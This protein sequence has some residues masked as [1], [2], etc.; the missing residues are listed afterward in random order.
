VEVF[1]GHGFILFTPWTR[2]EDVAENVRVI[3]D[4]APFLAGSIGLASRLCFYDPFNPIYRLA[5]A[6]GLAVRSARDYGL[7]FRFA[8]ARTDRMC[9]LAR[10]LE[11]DFI[12]KGAPPGKALSRAVLTAVAPLF[13]DSPDAPNDELFRRAE[14]AASENLRRDRALWP[15]AEEV[16]HVQGA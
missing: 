8:D 6:E 3:R 2:P 12:R 11:G 14:A 13:V 5:E 1:R 10:A 15:G 16:H 4:E 9:R 7:D